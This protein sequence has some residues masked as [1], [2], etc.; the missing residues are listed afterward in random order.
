MTSLAG[1]LLDAA[2]A[3]GDRPAL[4]HRGERI[5]Y[6]DLELR[7]ARFAG[8]LADH[9]VAA[10][11]RVGVLLPNEPDFVAAYFGALRLGAIA[12]P[13]NPLLRPAEIAARVENAGARVLVAPPERADELAGLPV[14][15]VDPAAAADA[16][17]LADVVDRAPR[18]A[19]VLLYTSGTSGG[20]KGAELTH[21][22][23]RANAVF[24]GR[25]VL[26][27][28][29]GDV[30]LG[31]TP[32]THILGQ[33]GVMNAAIAYGACVAL[34][35][36]FDA[37]A[38]LE[39]VKSEAA[40]VFLGVPT[41]CS[42]LLQAAEA[43]PDPPRLRVAHVGGAP[44]PPEMLRAFAERFG[45]PVLEGWGMTEVGTATS[46]RLGATVK[47]G[48]V[49]P[50][51]DGVELRVVGL[52]GA[53]LPTGE[54]GEVL[55]RGPWLMRGYWRDPEATAAAIDA[56][57]WLATGDMGYLDE[58]GY[59]FLVDRRKE[60]ILRGGYSVYPREVEDVL[61]AHPAVQEVAVVG[62]PHETLG[63]EVVAVVVPRPDTACNPDELKTW[64]RERVAAYKYPRLVV[65]ADRLPRGPTGKLLKREIDREALRKAL[66]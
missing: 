62:V 43:L 13:L 16:Q 6:R 8:V 50:A 39:L 11:D 59:L 18:D 9:G 25:E 35:P 23:L 33:A 65:L 12:L 20:A 61:H 52:D 42:A 36:R 63:E 29:P 31:S 3:H 54:T 10:G 51:V 55:V 41:M 4:L 30:L 40:G 17:P 38:S 32:L 64:A 15:L 28:S 66:P 49:G 1:L 56:D 5:D 46:H 57:G 7:S 24:L 22:G 19:A 60:L 53:D 44:L 14:A 47:P 34:M 26:G 27:L 21:A 37:Q 58:D 45:C 2:R 48:S